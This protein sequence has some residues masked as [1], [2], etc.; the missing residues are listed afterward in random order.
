MKTEL[1]TAKEWWITS[2]PNTKNVEDCK[3]LKGDEYILSLFRKEV[4]EPFSKGK[5]DGGFYDDEMRFA[6]YQ[7]EVLDK[8]ME[9]LN[10]EEETLQKI[11]SVFPNDAI[12]IRLLEQYKEFVIEQSQPDLIGKLKY[13]AE[14]IIDSSI[15]ESNSI[16]EQPQRYGSHLHLYLNDGDEEKEDT[17]WVQVKRETLKIFSQTDLIGKLKEAEEIIRDVKSQNEAWT[18]GMTASLQDKINIFL[19]TLAE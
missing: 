17:G 4:I 14:S 7:A 9:S 16:W 11:K 15:I 5:Y 1:E 6:I 8:Q 12:A 10:P 3:K 2:T 13:I 19:T 18:F